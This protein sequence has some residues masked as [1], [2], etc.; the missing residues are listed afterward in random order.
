[1]AVLKTA[2]FVTRGLGW[3]CWCWLVRCWWAV[4]VAVWKI[5]ARKWILHNSYCI[6]SIHTWSAMAY[7]HIFNQNIMAAAGPT[8]LV[9]M[10]V[11][12][13]RQKQGNQSKMRLSWPPSQKSLDASN[14][15]ATLVSFLWLSIKPSASNHSNICNDVKLVGSKVDKLILT[16]L[17]ELGKT[18]Q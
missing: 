6:N 14:R 3:A 17:D 9:G 12:V 2:G 18:L 4:W 11:C 1:M 10:C 8:S 13:F 5:S 16:E 15:W 7:E